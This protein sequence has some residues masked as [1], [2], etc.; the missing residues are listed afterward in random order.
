M[1]PRNTVAD[2]AARAPRWKGGVLAA[3][4]LA[5]GLGLAACSSGGGATAGSASTSSASAKS[6]SAA[7]ATAACPA[8]KGPG[9][10]APGGAP[11]TAPGGAPGG[12]PGGAPGGT[13]PSLPAGAV[14]GA[15]PGGNTGG[16]PMAKTIKQT[17]TST[18]TVI[19]PT[20]PQIQCATSGITSTDDITYS[21]PTTN[22]TKTDLQLDIQVPTAS[23]GEKALV[24][25]ITGGGF[26]I[27]DRTAN[28]DQ[29]TYV[30]DQGYVVVLPRTP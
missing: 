29:R 2:Q 30:A 9:G 24:I 19:N 12:T 3:A 27:A 23:T 28:L 1:H 22:G 18:S 5:A 17:D 4:T 10:K 20:G 14:P 16:I 26:S 8:S 7:G 15:I 25:Y 13:P 21:S 6:S 11:G